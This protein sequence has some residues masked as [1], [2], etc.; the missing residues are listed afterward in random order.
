MRLSRK[1]FS[2]SY[3]KACDRPPVPM[4]K[5]ISI[6][7]LLF[8]GGPLSVLLAA[9]KAPASSHPASQKIRRTHRVV[10]PQVDPAKDD[11]TRY[12]DPV[13]RAA[14]IEALGHEKGSVVA[15]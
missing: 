13:V 4:K 3:V 5:T 1:R 10:D 9:P 7:C 15:V 8:V 14:A 11:V 6:L 12:D 2:A